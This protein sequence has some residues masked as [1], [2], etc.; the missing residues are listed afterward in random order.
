[1]VSYAS[2]PLHV[3]LRFKHVIRAVLGTVKYFALVHSHNRLE[4]QTCASS[5]C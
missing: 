5:R 3:E 1:M 2:A 4:Q